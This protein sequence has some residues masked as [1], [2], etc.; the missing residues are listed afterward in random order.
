MLI[1]NADD[2]GR[3]KQAT[4]NTLA[5][6]ARGRLTSTSAMVFMTDSERAAE[7]ALSAKIDVGLHLNLSESFTSPSVSTSLSDC[8]GKIRRFLKSSKYSLLFFH[9][10]LRD[11]FHREFADQYAEFIRLYHRAP[12]H[13]DGHQHMHL[14]TNMLFQ[15]ILPSDTK[16]RR[17]FSFQPGEKSAFNRWYRQAVDRRLARR[18]RLTDYFF[19]LSQSFSPERIRHIVD[20]ARKSNVELMTHPEIARDH[21]FLMSDEFGQQIASVQLAGYDAL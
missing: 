18:H 3:S 8:H 6:H 20:L 21:D 12:S 14:A 7:L 15:N 1:I 11:H 4:D 19:A 9:P 17:S 10:F 5:C 2:L 16:V 13:I